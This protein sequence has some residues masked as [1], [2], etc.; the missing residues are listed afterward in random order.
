[1]FGAGFLLWGRELV[2]I[3]RLRSSFWPFFYSLCSSLFHS[4]ACFCIDLL[5]CWSPLQACRATSLC[6]CHHLFH[7]FVY[8]SAPLLIALAGMLTEEFVRAC[9]ATQM[10]ATK[11]RR[12][13]P[14]VR[15][16]STPPHPTPT[17][18]PHPNPPG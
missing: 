7:L 9:I 16:P 8:H 18:T 5:H 2:Q 14:Q 13:R 17:A 11:E 12:I 15:T 3:R 4:L 6:S 1:M 10:D